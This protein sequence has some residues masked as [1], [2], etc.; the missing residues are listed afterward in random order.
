MAET[1]AVAKNPMEIMETVFA[2]KIPGEE[3]Y[4]YVGLNGRS[5]QIPRGKSMQVPKPVADILR[6]QQECQQAAEEYRELLRKRMKESEEN[7]IY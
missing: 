6:R 1:K 2:P 5:W 7:P 4:V 3:G